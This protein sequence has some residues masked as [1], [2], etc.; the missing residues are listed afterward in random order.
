[1]FKKITRVIG[2]L[3][4]LV[5][6]L[7]SGIAAF[8]P[9][10]AIFYVKYDLQVDEIEQNQE[11]ILSPLSFNKSLLDVDTLLVREG[12]IIL[13][14][15][16]TE[17]IPS[18][19]PGVFAVQNIDDESVIVRII[20]ISGVIETAC[21][22]TIKILI[23]PF[24]V[25]SSWMKVI[26]IL[27]CAGLVLSI[28]TILI[29]SQKRK[30]VFG[31]LFGIFKLWDQKDEPHQYAKPQ[32][33]YCLQV[34]IF[35]S[36]LYVVMEWLFIV[37]KSSF[38][39]VLSFGAKLSIFLN[40]GLTVSIFTLLLVLAIFLLDRL[41]SFLVSPF[42]RIVLSIPA[43]L[44]LA[45]LGLI[46]VDNFTYTV[47]GFG[48]VTANTLGRILYAVGF[49]VLFVL[50]LRQLDK[51][52]PKQTNKKCKR[53][54]MS[55]VLILVVAALI[56]SA[57]SFNP[58]QNALAQTEL[59]ETLSNLPNI[60]LLS[61]D[62]L[63]AENMSVYGYERETT[64]FIEELAE[65]SLLMENN[66]TNANTS[67]GSDTAMLTGKL[68]FETGVLYPPNTLQ[69]IDMYE[70]LPGLLKR[71]G[72]KTISLGVEHFVDM[73]VINFKNAFDSVNGQDNQSSQFANKASQ[74]GYSDMVYFLSTISERILDRVQHIF[75]IKA[76]ENPYAVV[77]Q[78]TGSATLSE[79][80]IITNLITT[81]EETQGNNQPL[82]AH[83]HLISTHGPKFNLSS[84]TFSTGQAQDQDWMV[85]FYDDAILNYDKT[86]EELVVY[87]QE[88]G[89]FENTILVLYTDH[90]QAWT[91]D[92]KIPLIIHF[93]GGQYAGSVDTSTQN[94]DIAPTILEYLG[95]D[96]PS[97]MNGESLLSQLD[98]SRVLYAAAL[99]TS[100]AANGSLRE[101]SIAPPFFQFGYLDVIQC[102]RFHQI[103]L[104]ELTIRSY[105]IQSHTAPC[106]D[107][108]LDSEEEI[109]A[110]AGEMLLSLGYDLPEGWQD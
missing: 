65:E 26:F 3:I 95:I 9:G 46:L 79:Q 74:Y 20:P 97:W 34:V 93:P 38:M 78:G 102:Q 83:I 88:S 47:F 106:A 94:M 8:K 29:D 59:D 2:L 62:G 92:D 5:S 44:L 66:F 32:L 68:P 104:Q 27:L 75:F 18:S 60:I 11:I 98:Q 69:G 107:S 19:E 13:E 81:L 49:L 89:M 57:L 55:G 16:K 105:D 17:E 39:D 21:E 100:F 25:A 70:H 63:N 73:N 71:I 67:T 1:M 52:Q 51:K 7:M 23:R 14:R 72:Y 43:A 96:Q 48:V 80:A 99:K 82:F 84:Q 61:N 28:T 33:N 87:M 86:V 36:F 35:V 37:T 90:G 12:E 10:A 103:D 53:L 24:L 54:R 30:T 76:M 56:S 6:F 15:I 110:M 101:K 77:T 42:H 108:E 85:D 31:S 64:P 45:C 41:A 109:W 22:E 50:A 4:Y 58:I 40:T 91:V